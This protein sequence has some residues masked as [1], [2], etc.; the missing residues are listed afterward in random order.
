M[1]IFLGEPAANIKQWIIKHYLPSPTPVAPNGKVLYRTTADGEWLEDAAAINDGTF[2]GFANRSNAVEVVI[3]SRDAD[4]NGVTSIGSMA[5]A[6]CSGL[7]SVTIPDGVTS[8]GSA[9]F[10]ACKGLTSVTIPNS[11]TSIGA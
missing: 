6:L 11:V 4:G 7:K 10:Y 1:D 2:S 5:F 3:P 9:A 8:I